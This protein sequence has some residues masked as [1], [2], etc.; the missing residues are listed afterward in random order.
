MD[1]L[2][3]VCKA[4]LANELSNN[5]AAAYRFS[6]ASERSGL[7]FGITQ[8]DVSHNPAAVRCLKECGFS[9]QEIAHL[10]MK[11]E[12][13]LSVKLRRPQRGRR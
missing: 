10:K 5:A 2:K 8:L 7:S 9:E 4:L 1:L 12:G 3:A 11:K 6:D 13:G